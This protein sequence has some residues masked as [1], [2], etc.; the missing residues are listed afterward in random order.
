MKKS[1]KGYLAMEKEYHNQQ[2]L[3]GQH[4]RDVEMTD[5][6]KPDWQ[7]KEFKRQAVARFVVPDWMR[8]HLAYFNNT[9]GNDIEELLQDI[10]TTPFAN[11]IRYML[12][13]SVRSQFDLLMALHKEGILR[14]EN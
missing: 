8:P 5:T 2:I 9:G 1:N 7:E 14:D 4:R 12:I 10:T 3:R 11:V 6:E 13:V